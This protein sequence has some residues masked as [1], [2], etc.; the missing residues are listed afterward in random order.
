[1][2]YNIKTEGVRANGRGRG[3]VGT[4]YY[5]I[6]ARMR[7]GEDGRDGVNGGMGKGLRDGNRGAGLLLDG[8]NTFTRE[9][10]GEKGEREKRNEKKLFGEKDK[11]E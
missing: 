2:F 3:R 8:G 10:K 11:Y 4:P 1:M 9:G 5:I 6:R 7:S